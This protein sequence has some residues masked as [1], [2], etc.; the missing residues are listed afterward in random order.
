MKFVGGETF[1]L[2]ERERERPL[3]ID[4]M[5]CGWVPMALLEGVLLAIDLNW[6]SI[7]NP[8]NLSHHS[9]QLDIELFF[10]KYNII[11]KFA[12]FDNNIIE[13]LKLTFWI[14]FRSNLIGA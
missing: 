10:F 1:N 14:L 7:A 6:S 13:Y 4:E 11:F 8:F 5:L 12:F 3:A 9:S 2:R